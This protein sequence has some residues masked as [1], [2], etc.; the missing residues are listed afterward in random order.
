[1]GG[2]S[3][4]EPLFLKPTPQARLFPVQAAPPPERTYWGL[5]SPHVARELRARYPLSSVAIPFGSFF[6]HTSAATV[7]GIPLPARLSEDP[8]LHVTVQAPRGAPRGARVIGHSLRMPGMEV[9]RTQNVNVTSM[10]RTWCDLAGMLTMPE[11]VAAGDYLVHWKEPLTTQYMLAEQVGYLRNRR[12]VRLLRAAVIALD[13]HSDS[14]AESQ[15]RVL[16]AMV[17]LLNPV[18]TRTVSDD[19]GE[20]VAVTTLFFEAAQLVV[21]YWGDGPRAPGGSEGAHHEVIDGTTW[22]VLDVI[23]DDLADP[24]GFVRRAWRYGHRPVTPG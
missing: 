20:F 3:A 2:M 15:L 4:S 18:V 11:L 9:V 23:A 14:P 12:Y 24:R 1:M 8:R 19:Y 6:T 5:R 16:C 22:M 21:R 7:H 13:P 17:G 10:E